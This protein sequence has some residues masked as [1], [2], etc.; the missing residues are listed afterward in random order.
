MTF[1]FRAKIKWNRPCD[2]VCFDNKLSVTLI[3]STS[4]K[5]ILDLFL[6]L[7]VSCGNL[8]SQQNICWFLFKYVSISF[9]YRSNWIMRSLLHQSSSL[10]WIVISFVVLACPIFPNDLVLLIKN[11]FD[12]CKHLIPF[13]ILVQITIQE[14]FMLLLFIIL[15][16]EFDYEHWTLKNLSVILF[17]TPILLFIDFTRQFWPYSLQLNKINYNHSPVLHYW[18]RRILSQILQIKEAIQEHKSITRK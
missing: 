13:L 18:R 4:F 7:S 15:N 2:T 9:L 17:T 1:R 5:I 14:Y 11:Q 12:D 3:L 8:I 10:H 16:K 6:F